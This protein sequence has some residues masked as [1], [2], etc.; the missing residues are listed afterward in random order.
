MEMPSKAPSPRN[1]TWKVVLPI[2]AIVLIAGVGLYAS[3]K[4][5]GGSGSTLTSS[6]SPSSY[7]PIEIRVG[8]TLPDFV[9][10]KFGSGEVRASQ[11]D[12]RVTLINF[13]A[14]WCEPCVI[15]LPSLVKLRE[16]FK[17]K[18]FDIVAID[19]DENPD[20]VLPKAIQRYGL[21]FQVYLDPGQR[22]AEL[23]DVTNIPLTVVMDKNRK[24]LF[25]EPGGRDW[26]AVEAQEMV[27][28]WL[29]G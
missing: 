11:L 27:T 26:S 7:A 3:K 18:G 19:V 29:A 14:T 13:W 21:N 6:S 25:V 20:Q 23:F 2:V 4:N 22:L 28:R 15:E 10:T 16:K 5:F 1:L 12:S 17:P 24:I 8:T 9:L